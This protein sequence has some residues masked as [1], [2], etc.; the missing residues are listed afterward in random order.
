MRVVGLKASCVSG[1]YRNKVSAAGRGMLEVHFYTKRKR[2]YNNLTY[3]EVSKTR[4][5]CY[6][7]V[8]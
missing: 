1:Y 2:K 4:L 6:N 3:S 7:E 5:R 8:M